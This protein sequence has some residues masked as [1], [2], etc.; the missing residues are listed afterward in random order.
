M[1]ISN[2]ESDK[3]VNVSG[4][5]IGE[6]AVEQFFSQKKARTMVKFEFLANVRLGTRLAIQ[7]ISETDFISR[8]PS[9]TREK[10]YDNFLVSKWNRQDTL[11]AGKQVLPLLP[12]GST[13]VVAQVMNDAWWNDATNDPEV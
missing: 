12:L 9:E 7:D 4:R 2:K 10:L 11:W 8:Q 6:R 13:A 3:P 5:E 1:N